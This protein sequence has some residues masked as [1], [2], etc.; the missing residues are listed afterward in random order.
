M[1]EESKSENNYCSYDP[2]TV[3]GA[4]SEVC[5]TKQLDSVHIYKTTSNKRDRQLKNQEKI[6][7]SQMNKE[8]PHLGADWAARYVKLQKEFAT[9]TLKWGQ[10]YVE[11]ESAYKQQLDS[12]IIDFETKLEQGFEEAYQMMKQH[13]HESKCR[14]TE[15][16]SELKKVNHS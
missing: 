5:G 4:M 9:E 2:G 14:I 16:E 1:N 8:V 7:E 10:R 3:Q 15:L 13:K 6:Y 11:L 12:L